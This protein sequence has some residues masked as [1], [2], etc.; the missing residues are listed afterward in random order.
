MAGVDVTEDRATHVNE[1]GGGRARAY[2]TGGADRHSGRC[3][4]ADRQSEGT[5]K[6]RRQ[7]RIMAEQADTRFAPNRA[8]PLCKQS[9]FQEAVR[10]ASLCSS[11][12]MRQSRISAGGGRRGSNAP[13]RLERANKSKKTVDGAKEDGDEAARKQRI[14]DQ[15]AGILGQKS[16][17]E[18]ATPM[19]TIRESGGEA[20]PA[21]PSPSTIEDRLNS[22]VAGGVAGAEAAAAKGEGDAST[23]PSPLK[24]QTSSLVPKRAAVSR[25][26]LVTGG[27]KSAVTA[28]K[29]VNAFQQATQRGS[30]TTAQQA[31]AARELRRASMAGGG[32]AGRADRKLSVA[33]TLPAPT[34][35]VRR[36]S[37]LGAASAAAAGGGAAA[38]APPR[39]AESQ[40]EGTGAAD[41]GG[42]EGGES[43]AG[44]T[45]PHARSCFGQSA[46]FAAEA[47]RAV[48]TCNDGG[49]SPPSGSAAGGD[50]RGSSIKPRRA[51]LAAASEAAPSPPVSEQTFNL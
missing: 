22:G 10:R 7:E 12:D 23:S 33:V 16:D 14:K 19:E 8:R 24:R 18:G 29:T 26:D 32:S 5:F 34:D 36:A 50:R 35:A 42:A 31:H 11:Q 28:M 41:A 30:V 2:Q 48:E 21:T 1:A 39:Q 13:A 43:A 49:S 25:P 20:A 46:K 6:E 40:P 3:T 45:L 27:L 44:E 4:L 37:T 15:L 17:A 51:S 9:S 38:A 47:A